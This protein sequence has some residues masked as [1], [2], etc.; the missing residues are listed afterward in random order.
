MP[1]TNPKARG[2]RIGILALILALTSLAVLGGLKREYFAA[3]WH[4]TKLRAGMTPVEAGEALEKNYAYYGTS[5]L[6]LEYP[7]RHLVFYWSYWKSSDGPW[8]VKVSAGM[9]WDP[10]PELVRWEVR[11]NKA[12]KTFFLV[13]EC[14]KC[15]EIVSRSDGE[16]GLGEGFVQPQSEAD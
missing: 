10:Q 15:E 6:G 13:D 9:I 7:N 11:W 14:I 5:G 12:E 3:H 4:S 1:S 2:K 8:P 16:W